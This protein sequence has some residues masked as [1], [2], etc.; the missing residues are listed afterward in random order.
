MCFWRFRV[1]AKSGD[2]LYK[3]LAR[4]GYKLNTKVKTLKH[5]Y[6]FGYQL[7]LYI[8]IWL[9]LLSF[10]ELWLFKNP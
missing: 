6:T 1:I 5:P 10:F 9:F 4:F 7:E 2:D 3:D 8:E